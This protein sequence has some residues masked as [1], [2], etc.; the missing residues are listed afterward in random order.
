MK[1]PRHPARFVIPALIIAASAALFAFA[2]V[3]GTAPSSRSI[4]IHARRYAYD[5]PVISAAVG[6][7]LRL[8]MV[9]DDVVHGFSLD[10]H[11]IDVHIHPVA[12]VMRLQDPM[13]PQGWRPVDEVTVVTDKSGKFSYRCSNTCGPLHPFMQG[14]LIVGPNRPLRAALGAAAGMLLSVIY[15]VFAAKRGPGERNGS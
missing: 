10:G 2:P 6:D 7:T 4:L 12:P 13:S 11:G 8:T 15:L 9:S 14:T 5:P 1:R 3:G